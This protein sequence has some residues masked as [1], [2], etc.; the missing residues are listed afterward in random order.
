M[1]HS[2]LS[3]IAMTGAFA[4]GGVVLDPGPGKRARVTLDDYR[5]F[6]G[7]TVLVTVTN[8]TDLELVAPGDFCPVTLQ[9]LAAGAWHDYGDR[10]PCSKLHATVIGSHAHST[11][12]FVLDADL[13]A[14]AYRLVLPEP[15][16]RRTANA[17]GHLVSAEFTVDYSALDHAAW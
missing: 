3:L 12:P 13:P 7:Q 14:G 15:A 16:P 11:I 2:L 6:H 10:P 17:G 8:L 9:R 1:R 4:C 5:Y